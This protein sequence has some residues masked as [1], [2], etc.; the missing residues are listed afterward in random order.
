MI[1][2]V[3]VSFKTISYLDIVLMHDLLSDLGAVLEAQWSGV[4][5]VI[6]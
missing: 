5:L 4:L 3:H 1:T 2:K 6:D